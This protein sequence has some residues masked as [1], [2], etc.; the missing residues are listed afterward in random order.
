[1]RGDE[2]DIFI[3]QLSVPTGRWGICWQT[4]IWTFGRARWLTKTGWLV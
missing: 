4:F 2:V 1:M 3:V